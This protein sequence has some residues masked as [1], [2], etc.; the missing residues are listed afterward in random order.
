MIQADS[1]SYVTT[2]LL[3]EQGQMILP[4]E[5]REAQHLEPG[6]PITVLQFGNQLILIPEKALF[7]E[8]SNSFAAK[9]EQAGITEESL[10]ESLPET[11]LE[12]A[13]EHYPELFSDQ[14][15]EEAK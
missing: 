12:V 9:L 8:M 1:I 10:Q 3:G 15:A 13:K 6:D 5:F 4:E 7:E 11:R 2:A 14:P